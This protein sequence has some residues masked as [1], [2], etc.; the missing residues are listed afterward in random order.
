MYIYSYVYMYVS[1]G[2]PSSFGPNLLS[3]SETQC[4]DVKAVGAARNGRRIR[5]SFRQC[6]AASA[7]CMFKQCCKAWVSQKDIGY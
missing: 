7:W 2:P 6:C 1:V 4:V 3:P 5:W